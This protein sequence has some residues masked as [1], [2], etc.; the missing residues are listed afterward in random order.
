MTGRGQRSIPD[1]STMKNDA[2]PRL[3]SV[4]SLDYGLMRMRRCNLVPLHKEMEEL[5]KASELVV[6]D[7]AVSPSIDQGNP[8]A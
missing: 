2:M 3:N 8:P 7:I 1:V 4:T 5:R 6:V